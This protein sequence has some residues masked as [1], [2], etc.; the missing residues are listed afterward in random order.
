MLAK[1][2]PCHIYF[3]LQVS[4]IKEIS[5][6]PLNKIKASHS[7]IQL[8]ILLLCTHFILQN[9]QSLHI[10]LRQC[11]Y[12]TAPPVTKVLEFQHQDLNHY[13]EIEGDVKSIGAEMMNRKMKSLEGSMRGLRGFDSG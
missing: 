4:S 2:G 12:V 6:P 7:L 5:L 13:V 9:L 11:T 8:R 3:Q 1:N 10:T